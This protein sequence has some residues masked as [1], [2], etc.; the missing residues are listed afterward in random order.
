MHACIPTVCI[1][2]TLSSFPSQPRKGSQALIG[3][4]RE[5]KVKGVQKAI[6]RTSGARPERPHTPQ[7]PCR[8]LAQ[9]SRE[10][11]FLLPFSDFKDHSGNKVFSSEIPK[12]LH[13]HEGKV[14]LEAASCEANASRTLRLCQVPPP[15]AGPHLLPSGASFH[16]AKNECGKQAFF[17]L[18]GTVPVLVVFTALRP[19]Q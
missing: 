5:E 4:S 15:V 19:S 12:V 11:A 6:K 18:E 2:P 8:A 1:V 3:Q 7:C 14:C 17:F 16:S 13:T 10:T 9:L